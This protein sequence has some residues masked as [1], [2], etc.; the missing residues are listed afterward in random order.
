MR[1]LYD[2]YEDT[3]IMYLEYKNNTYECLIDTEDLPKVDSWVTKWWWTRIK[4]QD[5]TMYCSGEVEGK[6]K[7]LHRLIMECPEGYV[8]DHINKNGLDNRK[9]NLRIVSVRDN[10]RASISCLNNK[11]GCP[12]VHWNKRDNKWRAT[13][14]IEGKKVWL[15]AYKNLGD[16]IEARKKGE[17]KYWGYRT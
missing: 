7:Y 12:G 14:K 8:V 17:E 2:S 15:G 4:N 13:I 9:S 3:T 10:T 16:A 11:S 6:I 1:N 5:T